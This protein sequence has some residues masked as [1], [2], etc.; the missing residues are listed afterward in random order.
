M[1]SEARPPSKALR[2][3]LEGYAEPETRLA[4][5]LA[6]RGHTY[7]A[8][9]A[10]PAYGEC[11]SLLNTLG[12]IPTCH[13]GRVLVVVVV[14]ESENS[15]DWAKN[16]NRVVLG[17]LRS[18]KAWQVGPSLELSDAGTFLSGTHSDLVL[19]DRTQSSRCLPA[20]QGV[21][22]ARKIG[23]DLA[24][25]LFAAGVLQSPWI[26][27]TDA[28]VSLP[29]D[30]FD[31]TEAAGEPPFPAALVYDFTHTRQAADGLG[32]A[33]DQYEV[34]L[35]YLVLGLRYAGS[36]YA[37]HTIGSTIVLHADAYAAVRGFPKRV[38]AED[39]HLLAKL[40]KVGAIIPLRGEAILLSGRESERVPFGTGRA[41]MQSRGREEDLRIYDPRC[42][43]WL[44]TW[45]SALAKS[46]RQPEQSIDPHLEV[47]AIHAGIELDRLRA[48]LDRLG[49]L[50]A[51]RKI[52]SRKG[53]CARSLNENF[54]ALATLKFIHAVRDDVF[55]DIPIRD[56]LARAS[57]INVDIA[58][59]NYPFAQL[60][61]ELE[62][63][64]HALD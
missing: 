11:E 41:M 48:I 26:H 23:A 15:P 3:Y 2:K 17:A 60:C 40:A 35:R 47:A 55:P 31:R 8:L 29:V 16:A 20:K 63:A 45:I 53:D 46:A 18:E 13:R 37:F 28:D 27:C 1:A 12:T 4:S 6:E 22:L 30:Y 49:A 36:P 33:I 32:D 19:I 57:F 56:A 42:F 44:A 7:A 54:D 25:A 43:D 39:F 14:N 61:L 64:E 58:D 62:S 5:L 51:S 50:E 59:P 38:A 9:V 10:I 24:T 34:F 21:G 52:L